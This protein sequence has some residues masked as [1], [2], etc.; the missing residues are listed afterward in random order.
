MQMGRDST[1]VDQRVAELARRQH[2]VVSTQQLRALG[3]SDEM[4]STRV[5]AGTLHP[6]FRGAHAVG[7]RA[8]GRRGR[9]LAAVMACGEEA[10]LSHGSAAELLGF[11]DK[12]QALIHVI[13]PR[14]AGRKIDGVRWHGVRYPAEDEVEVIDGIPC[15][16]ASR[17]LVDLAGS[18]GTTALRRFVAQ[19]AVRRLL[20]V[21]KV[22]EILTR[23]RRRGARQ[24]RVVLIPWRSGGGEVPMLRSFFEARLF[25][26]LIEA[27]LPRPQCNKVLWLD[28][29]RIEVDVL[30]EEQRLAIETDGEETH[31]TRAAFQ[32]DR[33]RDQRLVAAGY[34]VARVTWAQIESEPTAVVARIVR[35][36]EVAVA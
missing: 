7:H 30:W 36:L 3:M 8:I 16:T 28:D 15:T 13:P 18:F 19:T 31:G 32:R 4:I 6:V 5:A 10:I 11:W 22:D 24:L 17:T 2:G 1:P 27:D 33:E 20:D 23:G 35:M 12:Q 14:R 9:M 29:R 21:H 34:R 26:A 25:P